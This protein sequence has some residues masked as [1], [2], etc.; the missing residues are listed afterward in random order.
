M[1]PNEAR[2]HVKNEEWRN[3]VKIEQMRVSSNASSAQQNVR[4]NIDTLE[5]SNWIRFL[6]FYLQ[7]KQHGEASSMPEWA[8]ARNSLCVFETMSYNNE[9]RHW[10]WKRLQVLDGHKF[11]LNGNTQCKE[12]VVQWRARSKMKNIERRKF[13]L[14]FG[15]EGKHTRSTFLSFVK[16]NRV[17]RSLGPIQDTDFF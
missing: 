7:C 5:Q 9:R 13:I 8:H 12:N 15:G 14:D 11:K 17:D 10:R 2:R 1:A 3:H 4:S 6:N 16:H